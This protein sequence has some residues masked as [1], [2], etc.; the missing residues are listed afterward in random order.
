VALSTPAE[1]ESSVPFAVASPQVNRQ[2]VRMRY[3]PTVRPDGSVEA[4]TGA[5]VRRTARK[6]KRRQCDDLIRDGVPIMTDVYPAG[7]VWWDE[8]DAQERWV[9]ISP[10]L[11]NRRIPSVHEG[12]VAHVWE[13]DNG[14]P[15]VH[16]DGWH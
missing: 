4:P 3:E 12:W 8:G 7:L 1:G 6:L 14:D 5:V 13:S 10:M 16:F 2:S 15:V 11:V 9:E